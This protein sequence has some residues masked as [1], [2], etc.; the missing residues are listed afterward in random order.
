MENIHH[1][2][3]KR[4]GLDGVIHDDSA[5]GRLRS[6]YIRLLTIEMKLLGYVPRIDINP[7]FTIEYNHTKQHY[8]FTLSLYG[9]YVGKKKSEWITAVDETKVIYTEKNR[10]NESLQEQGFQSNQK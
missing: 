2:P 1:K 4:F 3:L 7:D 10:S 9:V 5:I 6:E 8:T